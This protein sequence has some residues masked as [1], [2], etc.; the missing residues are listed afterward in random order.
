[1]PDWDDIFSEKGKVFTEPHTDMERIVKI[2]EERG[3]QKI[4]D[5]GEPDVILFSFLKR[6]L[7]YMVLTHLLKRFPLPKNGLLKKI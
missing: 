3:V 4:L 7:R 1:M 5:V 6:V 2:F